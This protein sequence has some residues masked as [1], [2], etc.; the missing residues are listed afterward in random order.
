LTPNRVPIPEGIRVM[1]VTAGGRHRYYC[2]YLSCGT[3]N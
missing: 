2:L 3:I 1:S